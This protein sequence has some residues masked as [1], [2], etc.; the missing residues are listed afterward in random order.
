MVAFCADLAGRGCL[1]YLGGLLFGPGR[2]CFLDLARV[3][4]GFFLHFADLGVA[5]WVAW[6]FGGQPGEGGCLADLGGCLFGPGRGCFSDLARRFPPKLYE[7]ADLGVDPT[8]Q[9]GKAPG[10]DRQGQ[11]G[12]PPGRTSI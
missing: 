6:P 3:P 2:G 12:A 5:D 1:A 8:D 7:F 9:V 11:K 4:S 10:P